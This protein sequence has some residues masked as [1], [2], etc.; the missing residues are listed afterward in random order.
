MDEMLTQRRLMTPENHLSIYAYENQR[1]FLDHKLTT[2]RAK[3]I[4]NND[5]QETLTPKAR[6]SPKP[7]K[8]QN[9]TLEEGVTK[10]RQS[11]QGTI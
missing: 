10:E 2:S 11:K 8:N 5:E 1:T 3:E 7:S 9:R 4:N 6:P